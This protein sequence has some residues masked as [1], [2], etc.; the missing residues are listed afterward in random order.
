M[1]SRLFSLVSGVSKAGDPK[2]AISGVE[3]KGFLE[4]GGSGMMGA[5]S[6]KRMSVVPRNSALY[7]ASILARAL[8][9]AAMIGSRGVRVA[10]FR[11]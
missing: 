4:V 2:L 9:Q 6:L 3:A 1:D 7:S 8:S 5:M 11:E 10:M